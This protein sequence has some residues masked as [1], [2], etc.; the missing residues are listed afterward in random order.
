[1]PADVNHEER[2]GRAWPVLARQA[3]L[4]G[5]M[6]YGELGSEISVHPRAL[7]YT[8]GPILRYCQDEGLP[9]LTALVVR[10]GSGLPGG[11]LI[12]ALGDTDIEDELHRVFAV[13]WAKIPNPFSYA[14]EGG[15]TQ[16]SMA[17]TLVASPGR[18]SEIY[19]LVRVRGVAQRVFREALLRAYEWS[20][21]FCGLSFVDALE[22][23]HIVPWSKCAGGERLDPRNGLLLCATHHRLFDA[24]WLRITSELRIEHDDTA[25]NGAAYSEAD[26]QVARALHRR[27]LR[28]PVSAA[29]LPAA[30]YI[31]R[32]A[33]Q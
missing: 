12:A 22:G 21:A 2:A 8:L 31:A 7:G 33:P 23:A 9:V 10:G 17:E 1:M 24:G 14:A 13:D 19:A 29:L 11:A 32:R 5:T 15:T 27:R 4:H 16:E 26:E 20:C 25:A 3:A 28:R 18:A 30:A 6:T